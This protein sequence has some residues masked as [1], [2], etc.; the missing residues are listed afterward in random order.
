MKTY[1]IT[2][3]ETRTITTIIE[4]E[5]KAEAEEWFISQ[6]EDGEWD[7]YFSADAEMQIEEQETDNKKETT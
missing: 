3:T 2:Y 4:A 1:H 7:Q 5:N 6:H